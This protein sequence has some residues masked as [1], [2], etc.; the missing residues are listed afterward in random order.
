LYLD[1]PRGVQQTIQRNLVPVAGATNDFLTSYSDWLAIQNGSAPTRST[2]YDPTRRYIRTGRDLAEYVHADYPFQAT[3][4]AAHILVT[5]LTGLA[6]D[7]DPKY[8]PRAY[9]SGNPYLGSRTQSGFGTFGNADL[10]VRL[11]KAAQYALDH[12]WFQK[13]LV[14]R[15][16]RPEEFG[17]RIH[18]TNTGA[19]NYLIDPEILY[20][21]ALTRTF[22]RT[23]SYLL[24]QAFPEGAPTHPA[25]PSG[26]AVFIGAG[27]TM[28]K[29]FLKE[30]FVIPNPVVASRDGLSLLPYSGAP[31][32]VLNELNK[33]TWNIALGRNFGGVHYRSD[34]REGL[35]LGEQVA[36]R[37]MQDLKPL[38]TEP[39]SGFSLTKFDG[40]TIVI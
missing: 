19:A 35:W 30:D 36:I 8:S 21:D 7:G 17:G 38:Y 29:A 5:A 15:R 18:H 26:H 1:V 2:T 3:L 23:N 4:N 24:P 20:S 40:T 37:L 25:Y 14:H 32:A 27:V 22:A 9:D 34:A 11:A 31:L 39:F 6:F 13:W 16:L 10:Q 28:L 33:L 12:A